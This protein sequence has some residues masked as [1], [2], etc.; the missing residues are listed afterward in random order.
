[1]LND[2]DDV[3]SVSASGAFS[4]VRVDSPVLESGDGLLDEAG[5]IERVGV[6]KSLDVIFVTDGEAGVDGCW[7]GSP[8]FVEFEAADAGFGLFLERQQI[9]IV[10]FARDAVVQRQCVYGL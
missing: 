9:R 10:A 2:T 3:G 1:M 7:G 5:F 4:M 6:D 8:V